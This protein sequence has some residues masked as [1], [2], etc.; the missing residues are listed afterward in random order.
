MLTDTSDVGVGDQTFWFVREGDAI[1][2]Y[3]PS[4]NFEVVNPDYLVFPLTSYYFTEFD[5]STIYIAR[6]APLYLG[7][8]SLIRVDSIL[9][10][11]HLKLRIDDMF[12][13]VSNC[14]CDG[15]SISW[16]AKII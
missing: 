4:F 2:M 5:V 6:L 3:M 13:P 7:Y 9:Q 11:L 8:P 15:V 1:T 16:K 10:E 14:V 12:I